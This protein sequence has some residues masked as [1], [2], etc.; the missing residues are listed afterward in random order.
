MGNVADLQ[1]E[2]LSTN[3][4]FAT[5]RFSAL[6]WPEAEG[7]TRK[8]FYKIVHILA[9]KYIYHTKNKSFFTLNLTCKLQHRPKPCQTSVDWIQSSSELTL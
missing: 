2:L 1:Q 8:T 4:V 3:A 5:L 9:S 7:S 6:E